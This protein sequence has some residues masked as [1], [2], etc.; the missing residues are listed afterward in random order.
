MKPTNLVMGMKKLAGYAIRLIEE[1]SPANATSIPRATSHRG[2]KPHEVACDGHSSSQQTEPD[3]VN[4]SAEQEAE[5]ID[6]LHDWNR[7]RNFGHRQDPAHDARKKQGDCGRQAAEQSDVRTGC[8]DAHV[9]KSADGCD[10]EDPKGHS[11]TEQEEAAY[12]HG[13]WVLRKERAQCLGQPQRGLQKTPHVGAPLL[14]RDRPRRE[15][16]EPIASRIK[17][18]PRN[19]GVD[20]ITKSFIH[21]NDYNMQ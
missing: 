12:A 21:I 6:R 20:F 3:S 14:L 5:K 1:S 4:D 8:A 13:R 7:G 19:R 2:S 15:V 16:C 17:D 10:S 18:G 9:A 11:R